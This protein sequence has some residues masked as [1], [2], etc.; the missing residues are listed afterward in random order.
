[1]N[2]PLRQRWLLS[3]MLVVGAIVVKI[4][5]NVIH[6]NQKHQTLTPTQRRTCS[7]CSRYLQ[8][9]RLQQVQLAGSSLVSLIFV[10]HVPKPSNQSNQ[11]RFCSDFVP[12]DDLTKKG[13][14]KKRPRITGGGTR[15]HKKRSLDAVTVSPVRKENAQVFAKMAESNDLQWE[16]VTLTKHNGRSYCYKYIQRVA[17][18]KDTVRT[19]VCPPSTQNPT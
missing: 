3:P 14:K 6:Q 16:C 17:L 4:K 11:I 1:M 7:T 19:T 9:A 13:D 15:H 5:G 10:N 12:S 18:N 2:L 8:S